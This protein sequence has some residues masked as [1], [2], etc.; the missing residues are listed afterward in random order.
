MWHSLFLML[1]ASQDATSLIFHIGS[2]A[3]FEIPLLSILEMQYSNSI[4][5]LG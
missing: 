4:Q 3:S 2:H 1:T 5:V